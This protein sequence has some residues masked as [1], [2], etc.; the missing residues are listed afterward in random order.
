MIKKKRIQELFNVVEFLSNLI[1]VVYFDFQEINLSFENLIVI[2]FVFYL[3]KIIQQSDFEVYFQ[4]FMGKLIFFY[5]FL[6]LFLSC[7]SDDDNSGSSSPFIGN[8]SGSYI[9]NEDSEPS[10]GT[11][12]ATVHSD[13]TITGTYIETD[14][15]QFNAS[16]TI[17]EHGNVVIG[18]YELGSD[19]QAGQFT[20][21]FT[22][23][24]TASGSW[25][26]LLNQNYHGTWIGQKQ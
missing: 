3:I 8:W 16:G 13:N 22:S 26:N 4:L 7:N 14:L 23:S 21:V 11:W 20:G 24:G 10:S 2:C 15:W 12:I 6:G 17:D 9:N 18:I 5:C 1:D 25:E 19:E